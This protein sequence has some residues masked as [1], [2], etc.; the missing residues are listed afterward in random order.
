[1]GALITP[2]LHTG[3]T[4]ILCDLKD[5]DVLEYSISIKSDAF[6]NVQRG[7]FL[8]E[9]LMSVQISRKISLVSPAWIRNLWLQRIGN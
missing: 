2:C 5:E 7:E 9:K 3:V 8:L 6:M 1:M 4:H